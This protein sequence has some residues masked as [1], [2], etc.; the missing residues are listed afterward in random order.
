MYK[1]FLPRKKVGVVLLLSI[2]FIIIITL[3]IGQIDNQMITDFLNQGI[4]NYFS[5]SMGFES[6]FDAVFLNLKNCVLGMIVPFGFLVTL[7]SFALHAIYAGN[8]LFTLTFL[9][10]I[11]SIYYFYIYALSIDSGFFVTL[12]TLKRKKQKL[13]DEISLFI[14]RLSFLIFVIIIT[15]SLWW[16]FS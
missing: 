4:I 5:S 2:F 7:F 6:L 3:I 8:Y 10:I 16:W 15:N 12:Y 13:R 9:E 11:F 14:Y 1:V